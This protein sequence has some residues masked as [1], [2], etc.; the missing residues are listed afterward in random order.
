MEVS[1]WKPI[2]TAPKDGRPLLLFDPV[3]KVHVGSHAAES[4]ARDVFDIDDVRHYIPA[5]WSC[6]SNRS[7]DKF[8]PTHWMPIPAP[9]ENPA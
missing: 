2:E 5:S 3:Y 4:F 1:E 7:N 9:P 8:N 6:W